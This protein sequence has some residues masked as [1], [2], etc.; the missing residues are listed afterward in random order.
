M[1]AKRYK[2]R[3]TEEERRELIGLIQKGKERA[4]LLAH[5][6]ILLEADESGDRSRRK[7]ADISEMLHVSVSTIERVRKQCVEE[8]LERALNHKQPYQTRTKKLDGVAEAKLI[9]LAC[10]Q[11]PEG[12]SRWTME[13]LADELVR[14]K[15]VES[16]APETVRQGLKKMSLNPG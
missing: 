14:L 11:A 15:V 4:R 16:I 8:G 3:L 13:L 10:T 6:R 2:I 9:Q 12:R 5:A 7:D 1:P